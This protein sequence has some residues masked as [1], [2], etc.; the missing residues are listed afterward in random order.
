LSADTDGTGGSTDSV[1]PSAGDSLGLF[2]ES[3]YIIFILVL[4]FVCISLA[5]YIGYQCCRQRQ[6]LRLDATPK[7]CPNP[8]YDG[9]AHTDPY[10]PPQYTSGD[11]SQLKVGSYE[12]EFVP[13][14]EES[15]Q[16]DMLKVPS[17]GK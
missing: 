16:I 2:P 9:Y 5:L 11:R 12:Y 17:F 10:P 15:Q 7:S 1:P 14:Y 13:T 3:M 6:Q 8:A 4:L